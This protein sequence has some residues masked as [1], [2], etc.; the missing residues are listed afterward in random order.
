MY[1][2]NS[3]ILFGFVITLYGLFAIL[4]FAGNGNIALY[5]EGAITLGITLMYIMFVKRKDMF[6]KAQLNLNCWRRPGTMCWVFFVF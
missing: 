2:S 5:F 4:E 3:K 1:I 6:F